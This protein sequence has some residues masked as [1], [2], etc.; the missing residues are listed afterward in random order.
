MIDGQYFIDDGKGRVLVSELEEEMHQIEEMF[1][2]VSVLSNY[3]FSNLEYS[4]SFSTDIP[5]I[6]SGETIS[7]ICEEYIVKDL[8]KD[9]E[10]TVRIYFNNDKLYAIQAREDLRFIFYVTNFSESPQQYF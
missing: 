1:A 4:K 7:C 3:N 5:E 10:K 8:E 2:R 6:S 9:A